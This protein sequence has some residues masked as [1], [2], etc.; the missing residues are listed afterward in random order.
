MAATLIGARCWTSVL[1]AD[2]LVRM[3]DQRFTVQ[4]VSSTTSAKIDTVRLN[5]QRGLVLV[6]RGRVSVR[7][8]GVPRI[9]SAGSS[10]AFSGELALAPARERS[11]GLAFMIRGESTAISSAMRVLS[12]SDI[13]KDARLAQIEMLLRE[14]PSPHKDTQHL[15]EAFVARADQL[16]EAPSTSTDE[17]VA[18]AIALGQ[19]DL[20]RRWTTTELARAVGV[21]RAVLARRFVAALGEPPDRHF[22][23]LRMREAAIRLETSDE[24]LAA[25]AADLGY[26][27]EFALS[28]AFKRFHRISPSVYRR[29]ERA[30]SVPTRMAA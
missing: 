25:I 12:S 8:D 2:M 1:R 7:R 26:S 4:R 27:S 11:E 19:S 24:G 16:G 30:G 17:L 5:A 23:S 21:S 13:L 6:T 10:I 15:V 22:T 9:V 28:R 20:S 29:R 3:Q 18:R 14:Q